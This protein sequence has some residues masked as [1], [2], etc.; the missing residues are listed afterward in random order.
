M[1]SGLSETG[2]NQRLLEE[3]THS[4]HISPLR[5]VGNIKGCA[6]LPHDSE[7]I[8]PLPRRR[9]PS[10]LKPF[11]FGQDGVF[12]RGHPH[13]A[14]SCFQDVRLGTTRLFSREGP[15]FEGN[16]I[17][18]EHRAQVEHIVDS[19]GKICPDKWTRAM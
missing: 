12:R 10:H 11:Q 8:M 13:R 9:A 3:V 17:D 1:R 7:N 19:V 14:C 16:Q 4:Q 5:Q 6:L 15:P 2:F 18:L